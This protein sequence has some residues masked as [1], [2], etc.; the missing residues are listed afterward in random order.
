MTPP[1][2]RTAR[3]RGRWRSTPR[4]RR[5]APGCAPR[6]RRLRRHA[7]RSIRRA[8]RSI[9]SG[10]AIWKGCSRPA[11]CSTPSR[12]RRCSGLFPVTLEARLD[13]G[14]LRIR[15]W[16]DAISTS[17]H[18]PRL[19]PRE[20]EAAQQYLARG[21]GGHERGRVA[22]RVAGPGG[23]DRRD[24]RG[25]GGAAADADQPRRDGPRRRAAVPAGGAAGRCGA[26][27]AE[28]QRA[29][30]PLDRGRHAAGNARCSSRWAPRSRTISP[31]GSTRRRARR[32]ASP[33]R[34]AVPSSCRRG[35]GG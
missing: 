24:A 22:R 11:T 30:R 31:S 29:A 10:C 3:R 35:C 15:V 17:T 12:G 9:S 6:S 18:D 16:P 21:G 7:P 5:R 2:A 13:P 28:G 8:A 4:A 1:C 33:T 14:R 23:R 32:R 25:V 34:R 27:R 19:T 26:V 20:A